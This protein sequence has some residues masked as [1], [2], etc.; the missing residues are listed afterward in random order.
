M[1]MPF[2]LR[3]ETKSGRENIHASTEGVFASGA[4]IIDKEGFGLVGG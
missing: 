4:A 3:G 1:S 2:L